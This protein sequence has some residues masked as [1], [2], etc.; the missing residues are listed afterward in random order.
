MAAAASARSRRRTTRR[1]ARPLAVAVARGGVRWDRVGRVALLI[2]LAGVLMLYVGPATSYFQTW[3]DAR[4]KRAEV[5]RLRADNAR[6]TRQR[7]VLGSPASLER[8]AREL[9]MVR[10]GERSF[11]VSGLPGQARRRAP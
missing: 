11:V 4:A 10:P 5:K 9:G 8:R 3:R 7:R 1:T 6:L 2:V